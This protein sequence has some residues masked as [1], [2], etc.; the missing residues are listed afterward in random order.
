[1]PSVENDEKIVN[2][3]LYS[4]RSSAVGYNRP[5]HLTRP[6]VRYQS[7]TAFRSP[8]IEP[9]SSNDL[10][11]YDP[12]RPSNHD[13]SSSYSLGPPV[14]P[15]NRLTKPKSKSTFRKHPFPLG[16]PNPFR[17]GPPPSTLNSPLPLPHPHPHDSS[18]PS[19]VPRRLVF[20][21]F[22][23]ED[24][25]HR[26]TKGVPMRNPAVIRGI[27]RLLADD[28]DDYNDYVDDEKEEKEWDTIL[29]PTS[30]SPHICDPDPEEESESESEEADWHRRHRG[31]AEMTMKWVEGKTLWDIQKR[32]EEEMEER[33]NREREGKR[34]RERK[35]SSVV[36]ER[37]HEIFMRERRRIS[38]ESS[39]DPQD[40]KDDD[41]DDFPICEM[42]IAMGLHE[43][44]SLRVSGL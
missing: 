41:F 24:E 35:R 27:K 2:P 33:I 20:D 13:G 32:K 43:S 11:R 30:S 18:H 1:M 34:Q 9:F 15:P 37:A 7:I 3:S 26:L 14:P 25:S 39:P 4:L 6:T 23:D 42:S 29:Y 8:W 17:P 44:R 31:T 40:E 12:P 22:R 10:W 19:F 36:N 16:G 21:P 5:S 28:E 38:R